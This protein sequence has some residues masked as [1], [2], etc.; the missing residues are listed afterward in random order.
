M[1][2]GNMPKM[3]VDPSEMNDNIVLVMT[4]MQDKPVRPAGPCSVVWDHRM[5]TRSMDQGRTSGRSSS[6]HLKVI[7]AYSS[8]RR[9]EALE[10]WWAITGRRIHSR[11]NHGAHCR[12]LTYKIRI[13]THIRNGINCHWCQKSPHHHDGFHNACASTQMTAVIIYCLCKNTWA[14]FIYIYTHVVCEVGYVRI[15]TWN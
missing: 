13:R 4:M 9:G 2:V 6:A 10:W 11:L 5:A 8:T 14:C 3:R 15:Q 7:R 1:A 12:E